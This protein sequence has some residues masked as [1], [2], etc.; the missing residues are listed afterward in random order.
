[1]DDVRPEINMAG[2]TLTLQP[3]GVIILG[4]AHE[5]L[6]SGQRDGIAARLTSLFSEARGVLVI[7]RTSQPFCFVINVETRG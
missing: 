2:A 7:E 1:M 5:F 4:I 6:S 3:D